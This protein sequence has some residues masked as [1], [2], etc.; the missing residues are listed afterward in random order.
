MLTRHFDFRP[1]ILKG[2]G[3]I[4]RDA[5]VHTVPVYMTAFATTLICSYVSERLRQ[6]YLL[7]L[8]G[9]S[10]NVVG[11]SLLIAPTSLGVKYAATFFLTAGSYVAMP[12]LVCS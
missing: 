10:L 8:F 9:A 12:I 6:R 11:L 1:T 3:Y 4:G 7:A 2:F 5:Q